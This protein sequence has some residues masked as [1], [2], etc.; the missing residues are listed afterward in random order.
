[1]KLEHIKPTERTALHTLWQEAIEAFDALD[2]D[3]PE[4][5]SV[6]AD[7]RLFSAKRALRDHLLNE[8]GITTAM[9][10]QAGSVL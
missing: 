6:A 1:M 3:A 8:H 5:E 7:D 9:L 4:A 2:H 10:N